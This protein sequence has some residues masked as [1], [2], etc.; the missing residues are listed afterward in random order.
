VTEWHQAAIEAARKPG[1]DQFA[2]NTRNLV[3]EGELIQ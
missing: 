3:S 1:F 2:D